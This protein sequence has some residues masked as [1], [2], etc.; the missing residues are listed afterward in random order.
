MT[1]ASSSLFVSH[2][3]FG[4]TFLT[5]ALVCLFARSADAQTAV[6]RINA[7]GAAVSPFVA[8]TDFDTGNQYHS[9]AVINTSGVVNAA[10]AAVYQ[11][12]RW[13]GSFTYTIPGLAAG[14][15]YVV[16]LHFVEL[17]WTAAGQ[18]AF[19]V[20]ING[21]NVL[22]NFD[23]F[24]QVGQ[25]HALEREF[26]ATANNAGQ[27]VVGFAKGTADNPSVAGIEVWTPGQAGTMSASGDVVGKVTVGY[28]GWCWIPGDG[29][30]WTTATGASFHFNLNPGPESDTSYREVEMWPDMREYS[31]A[32]A[33]NFAAFGNGQPARIFSAYTDQTVQTHFQWMMQYGID[34]AALQR[35]GTEL[36]DSNIKATRDA[37]NLK[38]KT[39]AEM[40]GRKFYVAYDCSGWQNF[41]PAIKSDWT[42]TIIGVQHLT[43]SPAYAR[44]NG[45]PVVSIWGLGYNSD[46]DTGRGNAALAVDVVN[47]FKAQGYYVIGGV[48]GGWRTGT[49]DSRSDF[50]SVYQA[51]DMIAPWGVGGVAD[52]NWVSSD[53]QTASAWGRDYQPCA[54]PGTSFFWGNRSQKNL[55][56]R[57]YGSFFWAY[58]NVYRQLG[59]Q[60]CYIAMFDEIDEGTA[61]FKVSEDASMQPTNQWF[62]SLDADGKHCSSDFYLRVANDGARMMRGQL[63]LLAAAPTLLV[64]PVSGALNSGTYEMQPLCAPGMRLD[65][66]GAANQDGAN[67]Q[68]GARSG[69]ASQM[70]RIVAVGGG[71]YEIAPFCALGRRIDVVGLGTANGTNVDIW[72]AN[73]GSNQRW[74]ITDIGGGVYE[75]EPQSAPG[76]RL[77]VTGQGNAAGTN[78]EIWQQNGS[79]AQRWLLVP[80]VVSGAVYQ[81][82]PQC[83]PGARLSVAGGLAGNGTNVQIN[84]ANGQSGQ[85]WTVVDVGNNNFELVPVSATGQRMDVT[86]QAS[87]NGTN[88]ET[89]QSTSGSNQRWRLLDTGAGQFELEP[90][91]APGKR[92]DVVG[93]GSADGT[94]VDILQANATRAQRWTLLVR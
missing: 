58:F 60:T 86:G 8:D 72:A 77:D 63:P 34:T 33:T 64:P 29:S 62:L 25:N 81:L 74:K 24:A 31:T 38:V 28:Q 3:R 82:A 36:S 65:V 49:G 94:N 10:P 11:S 2:L 7:G 73:A 85:D 27:I 76:L 88:V 18:R 20:A 56:P 1:F 37:M 57:N 23:I 42:N 70:M 55:F 83:A 78:I 32:F 93:Q 47:W 67:V 44:Q 66:A 50:Q 90:Q 54:Y 35:F 51:L 79:P 26:N 22:S 91:N 69:A 48:P 21:T 12:V 6:V 16:R 13:N 39:A 41:D 43:D 75:F 59:I 5:A 61:I 92:L 17:T 30:P 71:Y 15:S 80:A 53:L 4:A 45:K 89:Y 46:T 84:T 9:T 87:A 52:Y 68:L 40:Y 14:S 19:N